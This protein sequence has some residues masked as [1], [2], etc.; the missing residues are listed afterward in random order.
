MKFVNDLSKL[1]EMGRKKEK[2]KLNLHSLMRIYKVFG[3]HYKKYWKVLTVAYVG[4]LLGIGAEMLKPWPLKLILDHLILEEP[5]PPT[6][7]FL[8]TWQAS[9]PKVLLLV[10]SLSIILVTAIEAFF[11]YINK[12]W[13]SSTGDRINADIRERVF[14][15]LQRLSLSF[16]DSAKSG[17]L[18]YLLT[19][20]AK[21][22]K[23]ILIDF[24]QDFIHRMVTFAGYT[25]L[26]M[27]LD[28]RLGLI[29]IST[30]PFIY[31]FTRYFGTGMKKAMKKRRKQEG[32]VASIIA[33][34]LT[35]MALVQAYGREETERQRFNAES[36][37][38][39]QAQLHA[40]RLHR[41][42]SRI[43][44]FLVTLSTAGVLYFGGRY[45]LGGEILP[46]TL[47]V[48]VAYLRD[49]YGAFE[50]FSGLF[51]SLAKSQVSGE[52]LLEL[53]E[54][55]MV[56][57]D[58][59]GVSAAPPFKGRIEFKN[60]SFA[61]KKGNEVLKNLNFVVEPG[62]TVALVGHSG[63]G[64]STLISLLLRFYDPQQGQILIDGQ[65]IRQ[66]TLKSLRDQMT[67]VLQDAKLFRQTVR[68]NIAFGK[69]GATEEEIVA[70]AKQAEAHDF[71][72]QMPQG[73][74]T[75]MFEG[76]DNLSGGQKQ[77]LNIARA[78]IRN[79]PIMILDEPVTGLD[80]SAE[81]KVNAAIHRLTRGKTTFI[82]AH[83]FSTIARADK[84]LL[85]QEGQLAHQGTHEQLLRESPEYR[86]LYELQ[87]GWQREMTRGEADSNGTNGKIEA[88][89]VAMSEGTPSPSPAVLG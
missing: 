1:R 32:E 8:A 6:F 63:A 49:I 58:G 29:A 84:I 82:V 47:V 73:Y 41:T 75:M 56:M 14:A 89:E 76:G 40:L 83:K 48:F 59:P 36:Q 21:E 4:L 44:D 60:V 62:E 28:W 70:A 9:S 27:V 50:K 72:M 55:D 46:G 23:G 39:L 78:V 57:Q 19:S 22:M 52:R 38:S 3:R 34:N 87:F 88:E 74:D 80:A 17:N 53:L 67:I 10:L 45:A 33:E 79:T 61:Y 5:L 51:I 11:S 66:F 54:N 30:V 65:D 85:L 42:Y 25:A 68:E 77:R 24:P 16:H 7:D 18:I 2:E 35:A 26:M 71:I 31:L 37:E 86:E 81:A 13:V 64:K 12:F 20:D 15:H 43:T 69:P